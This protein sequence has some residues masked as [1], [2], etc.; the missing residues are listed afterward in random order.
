M[1]QPLLGNWPPSAEG[2]D[3]NVRLRVQMLQMR[4]KGKAWEA[5]MGRALL[6]GGF[7]R[8]RDYRRVIQEGVTELGLSLWYTLQRYRKKSGAPLFLR[9]NV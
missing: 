7:E 3:Y 1:P 5:T 6:R 8:G 2:G 9:E 4:S